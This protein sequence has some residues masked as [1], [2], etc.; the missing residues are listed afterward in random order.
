LLLFSEAVLMALRTA[1]AS[2]SSIRNVTQRIFGIHE[3]M[4]T[5][6]LQIMRSLG[7]ASLYKGGGFGAHPATN[8]VQTKPHATALLLDAI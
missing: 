7:S 8:S 1:S 4:G 2:R 5:S 3:P 6:S